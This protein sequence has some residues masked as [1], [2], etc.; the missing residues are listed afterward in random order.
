MKKRKAG[1]YQ[2][3]T[4][5]TRQNIFNN[6]FKKSE[7]QYKNII[8]IIMY[9]IIESLKNKTKSSFSKNKTNTFNIFEYGSINKKTQEALN[10]N[11]II[12]RYLIQI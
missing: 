2:K 4:F 10:N 12:L 7:F 6:S 1:T 5:T 11:E 8:C 9:I 3:N